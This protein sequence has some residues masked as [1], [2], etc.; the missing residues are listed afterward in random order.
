MGW[1]YKLF[2]GIYLIYRVPQKELHGAISPVLIEM[3]EYTFFFYS[4]PRAKEI[5]LTMFGNII[6]KEKSVLVIL[7]LKQISKVAP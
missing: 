1:R 2:D 6:V 4:H 7:S 5:L 3:I